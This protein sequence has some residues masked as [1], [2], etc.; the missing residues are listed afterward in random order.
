MTPISRFFFVILLLLPF[1]ATEANADD[2]WPSKPIKLVVP[3]A[4]GL[5]PDVIRHL[6][7]VT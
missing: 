2:Q 3:Y 5:G 4:P 1:M 6:L 7:A